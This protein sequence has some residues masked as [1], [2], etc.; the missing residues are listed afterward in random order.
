VHWIDKLSKAQRVVVVIAVGVACLVLGMYLPG[1]G[2][3]GFAYGWTGYAPFT[4]PSLGW[5]AWLELIVWLA[6]TCLWA[7]VS[8]RVLRSSSHDDS[9]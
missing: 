6:L 2:Q 9:Q 4:A 5:P 1:L 8:I 7:A 3:R